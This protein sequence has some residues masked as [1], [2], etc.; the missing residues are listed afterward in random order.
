MKILYIHQ[1]FRT[2]SEPGGT[3]SWEFARRL[4]SDGHSVTV[5]CGG[6]TA[7][8]TLVEGVRVVRL[9]VSYRNSM[10]AWSRLFSFFKFIV[11]SLVVGLRH[12]CDL[13]FA[14]STPLTVAVP[15]M[16]ISFARR[17]PLVFEVR[18]LW[19]ETPRALGLLR[20]RVLYSIAKALEIVVYRYST[21]I[22]ALSPGM[23]RGVAKYVSESKVVVIPNA[24]DFELF[25]GPKA[26]SGLG[27]RGDGV[28]RI[29]YAGSFGTIYDI[30]WLIRFTSALAAEKVSVRI[31]GDGAA[32]SE[33]SRLCRALGLDESH[34]APG[35]ISKEQVAREFQQADIIISSLIDD[36]ALDD[37]SLNKVFD[38]MAAG[39]P[40]ALNH[41]GW[42]SDLCVESGAG[43][44]LSRDYRVAAAQLVEWAGREGAIAR[45]GVKA[46]EVGQSQFDRDL[47]YSDF[48]MALEYALT[49]L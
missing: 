48:K 30:P 10:G 29:V 15:G 18:D 36:S 19:P 3:R 38:A 47:L 4:V 40:I 32:R 8:D 37:S 2:S 5:V 45:A 43:I 14:T 46:A 16:L 6:E 31:F 27:G 35:M 7:D 25:A 22:I 44:R 33:V 39:K 13:V 49:G 11:A 24:C 1:H 23:A 21:R 28:I 42:L 26:G 9:G 20:S 12:K 17:V 34:V 41:R